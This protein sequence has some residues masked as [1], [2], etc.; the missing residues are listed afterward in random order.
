M[1]RT[2]L[3]E[4]VWSKP[5]TKLGAELGISDVGLAKACRRHA[6][7]VPARG[8]WAKLQAGKTSAQVPLPHPE[9]DMEVSFTTM[10]PAR[11]QA[12]VSQKRKAKVVVAKKAEELRAA[13]PARKQSDARPHPLVRATMGYLARL[14]ARVKRWERMTPLQHVHAEERIPPKEN[15]RWMLNVPDGLILTASDE[16]LPWALGFL[17]RVFKALTAAG[18]KVFRQAEKDREPAYIECAWGQERLKLG[19]REGYRR[20]NLTAA[21]FAQAKADRSWAK[22]WEYLPSGTFTLTLQGSERAVSKTWT[23]AQDKLTALGDDIVATCL[24]LLESQ[25]K[26]REDRLA[27]ERRRR[28]EAERAE[29]QRRIAQSRREQLE[30]AFKAAEAYEKVERLR[31][32]LDKVEAEMG[33]YNAPFNERAPVWLQLVRDELRRSNPYLEIL[34]GSMAVP[35]WASW[36]P[37]WWPA[38]KDGET[39]L[40]EREPTSGG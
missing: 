6:V 27:E 31:R 21:E 4:L 18:V 23:G 34:G 7:P 29:R 8:H 20:V 33:S 15:G 25:P 3:Y 16:A 17:D 28:A 9:M 35:S 24:L 38:A 36:P 5:M 11:R 19:F 2:E 12:E 40:S 32:F 37:E 13:A 14:P 26:L 10:P 30:R 39:A 1:K 22:D